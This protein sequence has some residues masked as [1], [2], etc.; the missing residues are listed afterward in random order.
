MLDEVALLQ[1]HALQMRSSALS[2][3][4]KIAVRY[5]SS[6]DSPRLMTVVPGD[7]DGLNLLEVP[8]DVQR[9]AL[10]TPH[11]HGL[12]VVVDPVLVGGSAVSKD[13][14]MKPPPVERSIFTA[15]RALA[16]ELEL[17][18]LAKGHTSLG[19]L[20]TA[21]AVIGGEA[22]DSSNPS[23]KNPG[24]V[25][26]EPTHQLVVGRDSQPQALL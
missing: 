24:S 8:A 4:L 21:Y 18:T 9:D 14:R 7:V 10:D 1:R 23:S 12:A 26:D 19:V 20:P 17:H 15:R 16:G 2:V 25:L 5:Q 3:F 13:N 22:V 6:L 11:H